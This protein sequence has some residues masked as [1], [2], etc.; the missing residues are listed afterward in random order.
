M[1]ESAS[2]KKFRDD[3]IA[4]C[5]TNLARVLTSTQFT[6]EQNVGTLLLVASATVDALTAAIAKTD[7]EIAKLTW[8]GQTL[9]SLEILTGL[10]EPERPN[11]TVVK[12][13]AND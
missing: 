2:L 7:A 1:T 9:K 12:G 11:L 10:R 3:A 13:D 6:A 5:E 8:H 4:E